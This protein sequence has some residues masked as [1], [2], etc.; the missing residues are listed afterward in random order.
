MSRSGKRHKAR[1]A[2][3]AFQAAFD[4]LG[5]AEALASWARDKP[6]EFYRLFARLIPLGRDDGDAEA[7][8]VEIIRFSD[9]DADDPA[10]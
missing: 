1:S 4:E 6:I 3:E 7:L 2:R 9:P 5:G 8:E 10:A